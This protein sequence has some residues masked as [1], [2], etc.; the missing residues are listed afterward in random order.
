MTRRPFRE[1]AP[2]AM[3]ARLASMLGAECA[4]CD[5]RVP[6]D[7]EAADRLLRTVRSFLLSGEQAAVPGLGR[8]VPAGPLPQPET[9]P[10]LIDTWVPSGL[11]MWARVIADPA[12]GTGWP[13]ALLR[14]VDPFSWRWITFVLPVPPKDPARLAALPVRGPAFPGD[15]LTARRLSEELP[16]TVLLAAPEDPRDGFSLPWLNDIA[17]RISDAAGTLHVAGASG[18]SR[19]LFLGTF[20]HGRHVSLFREEIGTLF[21]DFLPAEPHLPAAPRYLVPLVSV[22][23]SELCSLSQLARRIVL[24]ETAGRADLDALSA[25][26]SLLA[27]PAPEPASDPDEAPVPFTYHHPGVA[28]IDPMLAALAMVWEC[29]AAPGAIMTAVARAFGRFARDL[30]S[31]A[32]GEACVDLS[33]LGIMLRVD[34]PE[35]R[36]KLPGGPGRVTMPQRSTWVLAL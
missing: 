27:P 18:D 13:H 36:A 1:S 7:H 8:L 29:P 24:S 3:T 33:P 34:E 31:L 20:E 14:P 32:T 12:L 2:L 6:P 21:G 26:A 15:D 35:V 25:V 9:H 22:V 10:A 30:T 19:A 23:A 16:A 5:V 4:R 11:S 17:A 28:G